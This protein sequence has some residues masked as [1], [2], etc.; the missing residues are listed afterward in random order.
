[1]KGC[2]LFFTSTHLFPPVAPTPWCFRLLA[3]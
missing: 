3:F 2:C 1:V